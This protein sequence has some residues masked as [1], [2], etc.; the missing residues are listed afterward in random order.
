MRE[1]KL[2]SYFNMRALF[3][4]VG[5]A[6]ILNMSHEYTFLSIIIGTLSGILFL[7][8]F[9]SS[10]N[11]SIISILVSLI[12]IIIS[13]FILINMV[14][15]HYLPG[16]PKLIVSIPILLLTLYMA[17]KSRII[18]YRLSSVLIYINIIIFILSIIS[19]I[20]YF[21]ISSFTFTDTNILKILLGSLYY[22]L[23]SVTPT[24][25]IKGDNYNLVKTYIYSSITLIL[26][27]IL[28]Y[29]ILGKGL[30]SIL[31]YPEYVILK[32]VSLVGTLENI[33]NF[34]SFMWLIDI[35]ILIFS[36]VINI[37]ENLVNKKY[38]YVLIP[39]VF[40]ITAIINVE[41]Y[42]LDFIY[43][44]IIIIISILFLLNILSNKKAH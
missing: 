25:S 10:N 3:M 29:G 2:L 37:K 39:I 36:N 15:S 13:L 6:K 8:Y 35:V 20:P 22:F 31:R 44:N 40:F 21:S 9:R 30:V 33:E 17:S 12:T 41:Y 18:L 7:K 32:N 26:W 4:G 5:I 42:L 43:S 23:L 11:K 24:L 14:S 28:T 34:V 16:M 1:Y 27:M 38:I 19:L